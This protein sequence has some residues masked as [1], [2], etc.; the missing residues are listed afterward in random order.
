MAR[1]GTVELNCLHVIEEYNQTSLRNIDNVKN[2][3]NDV[4]FYSE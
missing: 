3:F 4:T 1:A 2:C